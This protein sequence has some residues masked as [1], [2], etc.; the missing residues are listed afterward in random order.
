MCKRVGIRMAR[1]ITAQMD[2]QVMCPRCLGEYKT[3]Q[4][5]IREGDDPEF[6]FC[7]H[8]NM[9]AEVVMSMVPKDAPE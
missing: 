9:T 7:P 3:E 4:P 8:C 1:G 2:G 6:L 5:M